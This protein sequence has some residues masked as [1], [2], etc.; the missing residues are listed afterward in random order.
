MKK[1]TILSIN[2]NNNATKSGGFDCIGGFGYT[3]RRFNRHYI[4]WYTL[5]K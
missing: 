1:T 3:M 5:V 2:L 4:P